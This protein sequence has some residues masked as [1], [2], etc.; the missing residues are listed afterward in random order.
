M[1]SNPETLR[2]R[3]IE[4]VH[5]LVV[6]DESANVEALRATLSGRGYAVQGLTD[7]AAALEALKHGRFALLLT[8]LNM[9]GMSGVELLREAQSRDSDLVGVI[10]T[11]EGAI[12][13]AVEAMKSGALD[14]VL[15]PLTLSALLPIIDRAL[16]IRRLR[17]DN[18]ELE[19]G[20]RE[21]ARELEAALQEVEHQTAE[22]IRAEQAL[23]QAQ[24]I[25]AIGRLTGGVAHDFNNLLTAV[26]GNLELLQRKIDVESPH[27]RFV[28]NA[29]GAASRGAK[30]TG[31]L[32]AF[33]RTQRLTLQPVPVDET[34]LAIEPLLRHGLGADTRLRIDLGAEG[35]WSNTDATQLELAALN[36]IV[37]ARDA[38]PEGGEIRLRTAIEAD[39][40]LVEISDDGVGM[41][42]EVLERATEP[43]FTTKAEAGSGLGLAQVYGFARQCGGDCEIE[44][45]PAAGTRVRIVLPRIEAPAAVAVSEVVEPVRAASDRTL[46]VLVVDDDDQVRQSLC[47]GL[48]SE[49]FIVLEAADGPSGLKLLDGQRPDV[50]VLDYAMPL[51]TGA[52]LARLAQAKYPS[53][54]IVFCSG[55]ADSL[56]LDKIGAA[57]VLRKPI[58]IGDLSRAVRASA[59]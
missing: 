9:P 19:R 35:A 21:R 42:P 59:A 4:Q 1:A 31:Q 52:E 50:A 26:I 23:M 44:S 49:G 48:A 41:T 40:V 18:A 11:G 33:S 56:A 28:D 55:Y 6:D 53:L 51:M 57:A 3:D 47:D 5:I 46:T 58:T 32:L 39:R 13:S 15:K 27:R 43:F 16:T 34:L 8:D 37:N 2:A 22:R 29:L 20:L 7:S 54:P 10:M 24:K 38:L 25:E 14:Y 17:I 45:A 30:V 36:L 12:A